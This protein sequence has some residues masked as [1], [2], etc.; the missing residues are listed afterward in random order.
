MGVEV[1]NETI[2]TSHRPSIDVDRREFFSEFICGT[3]EDAGS[4]IGCVSMKRP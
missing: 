4:G 1:E 3:G 2:E